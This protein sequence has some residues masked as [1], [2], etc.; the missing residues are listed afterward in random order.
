[1]IFEFAPKIMIRFAPLKKQ[2]KTSKTGK[3]FRGNPAFFPRFA[4]K[5]YG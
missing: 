5:G 4:L 1:M 2:K 3:T